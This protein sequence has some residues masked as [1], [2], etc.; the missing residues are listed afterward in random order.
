MKNMNF[1]PAGSRIMQWEVEF[2]KEVFGS[3]PKTCNESI[4]FKI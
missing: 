1:N 3:K 4:V 2:L